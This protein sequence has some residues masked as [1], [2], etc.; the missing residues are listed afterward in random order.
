MMCFLVWPHSREDLDLLFIYMNKIDST[1]KMRFTMEVAKDV[2]EFPDLRLKFDNLNAFL[3]T[4][5]RCK[6]INSFTYVLP[7]NN[8]ENLNRKY[9]NIKTKR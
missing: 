9:I 5:F 8:I 3:S 4:F 1:K 2:L 7:K 6:A